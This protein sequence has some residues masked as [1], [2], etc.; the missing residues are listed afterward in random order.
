MWPDTMR[1][2]VHPLCEQCMETQPPGTS[3][4]LTKRQFDGEAPPDLITACR[5]RKFDPIKWAHSSSNIDTVNSQWKTTVKCEKVGN[6][7]RGKYHHFTRGGY[8]R[9]S[10][11]HGI[12]AE[13]E[14]REE[15]YQGED[16]GRQ[17]AHRLVK[18]PPLRVNQKASSTKAGFRL[19]W[20]LLCSQ[21]LEENTVGPRCVDRLN[22]SH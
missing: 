5:K 21:E 16:I 6:E 20:S 3:I 10:K 15:V 12:W 22:Q 13:P 11:D 17:I 18:L 2:A 8:G 1:W 9:F 4:S 7:E 19:L 14:G